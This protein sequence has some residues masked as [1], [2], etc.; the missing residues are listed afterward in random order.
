MSR[1]ADA[2]EQLIARFLA[3][4]Q[5][6]PDIR[7]ALVLGSR[8]RTDRPADE[9]SDL[10]IL[11]VVTDPE[12]YL[13]TTDW[14]K[15]MGDVRIT[16][17]EPTAGGN[18]ERRVLFE[19]GLDVD[20]PIIPQEM[21][22]QMA[23]HGLP[24]E[25]ARIFRRG[26]RV[27]IDRDRLADR[28]HQADAEPPPP[29]LPAQSE[30]LEA[31]NDFW[32]HAVWTAKKLKRGELWTARACSDGY[33]KR[34]LLK[35]IEWHAATMNG[36]DRDV[37]HDG[38]FLEQWADPRV[39]EGLRRAFGH[40]DRDDIRRAL[41]AMMDL[42][43]WLALEVTERLD[44]RY[45]HSTDEYATGLVKMVLSQDSGTVSGDGA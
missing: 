10:D 14:L 20:F 37:W 15:N 40:Y 16:F 24:A 4:A 3:W 29:G 23:Q 13:T 18:L 42:F 36:G 27:L 8:A 6:R 31:I 43:R 33:M 38:R 2:Y 30:V 11:L 34:L 22:E 19:G 21:M 44:Y 1:V 5:A 39:P 41:L 26:V 7:T 28:L 9:W 35:M 12:P 45:P 25:V 32:Y 17:L